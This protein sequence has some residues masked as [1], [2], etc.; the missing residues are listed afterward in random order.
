MSGHVNADP[1]LTFSFF[2]IWSRTPINEMVLPTVRVGF[3]G[4]VNSSRNRQTCPEAYS[5]VVLGLI[6]LIVEAIQCK[7][8]WFCLVLC[9][10]VLPWILNHIFLEGCLTKSLLIPPCLT[11]ILVLCLCTGL[12]KKRKKPVEVMTFKFWQ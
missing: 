7:G 5:L 4:S 11:L 10:F 2:F 8:G 12:K 3:L 9:L 1:L 6:K